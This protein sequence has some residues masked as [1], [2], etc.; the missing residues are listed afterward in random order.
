MFFPWT[1]CHGQSSHERL[2]TQVLEFMEGG[3][4]HHALHV[5]GNRLWWRG[6]GQRIA[7]DVVRGLAYLHKHSVRPLGFRV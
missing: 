3:D 1:A 4:L 7:L 6:G 2:L 5:P